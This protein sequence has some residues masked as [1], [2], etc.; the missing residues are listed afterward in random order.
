M[1]KLV[2]ANFLVSEPLFLL[3]PPTTE[4]TAA[5]TPPDTCE[6][7]WSC[8]AGLT[9]PPHWPLAAAA[10]SP[11][12]CDPSTQPAVGA[13]RPVGCWAPVSQLPEPPQSPDPTTAVPALPLPLS[14][15]APQALRPQSPS[16]K[17]MNQAWLLEASAGPS[18]VLRLGVLCMLS[19]PSH[20]P[21][22]ETPSEGAEMGNLSMSLPPA[23]LSGKVQAGTLKRI[24]KR[25]LRP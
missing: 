16:G 7:T 10:E 5:T 19:W 13:P 18:P 17:N 2:I 25:N 22:H 9:S 4:G 12:P 8:P 11:G 23:F 24:L 6:D 15:P 14:G 21:F 1:V 20:W 3:L